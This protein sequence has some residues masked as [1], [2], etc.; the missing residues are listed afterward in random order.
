LTKRLVARYDVA[1]N[2]F[3]C[4]KLLYPCFFEFFSQ[5]QPIL[6]PLKLLIETT[7]TELNLASEA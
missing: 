5:S 3:F 1:A 7:E 2:L 4:D 6:V